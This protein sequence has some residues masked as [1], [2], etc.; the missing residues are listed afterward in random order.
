MDLPYLQVDDPVRTTPEVN[1]AALIARIESTSANLKKLGVEKAI[2]LSHVYNI[3]SAARLKARLMTEDGQT[4]LKHAGRSI[5]TVMGQHRRIYPHLMRSMFHLMAENKQAPD[6]DLAGRF[7]TA[8]A[9]LGLANFPNQ[10]IKPHLLQTLGNV[11]EGRFILVVQ[12]AAWDYATRRMAYIL[13][14]RKEWPDVSAQ[15]EMVNGSA[16]FTNWLLTPERVNEQYALEL[17]HAVELAG[18]EVDDPYIKDEVI[19]RAKLREPALQ[20]D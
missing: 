15:F 20:V 17:L 13:S 12:D 19:E 4:A 9:E 8:V 11:N 2:D 3:P 10:P 14:G 1:I 5:E 18:Y 6:S 16:A 7:A